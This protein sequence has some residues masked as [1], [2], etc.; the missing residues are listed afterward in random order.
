MVGVV[1]LFANVIG[2]CAY[3]WAADQILYRTRVASLRSLLSQTIT[4]HST[5]GRTP[6]ALVAFITGDASALSGI[7]GTTI[8]LLLATLVN[9]L[10]GIIISFVVAWNISIILVPTIPI[11]LV[12]GVM[13]LRTQSQFAE[14]HKKAFS[15]ATERSRWKR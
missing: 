10:A 8:G 2:G 5:E 7:T 3:G 15:K 12:A 11:L 14:R 13:K 4:W 1:E 9:L 6:G